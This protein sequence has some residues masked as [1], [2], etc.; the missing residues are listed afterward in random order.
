ML[1]AL[2]VRL[3]SRPVQPVTVRVTIDSPRERAFGFLRDLANRPAFTD[4]FVKR[5]HLERIPS[6]G[7]GASARFRVQPL[8]ARMWM[9]TVVEEL[10]APHLIRERGR[11]GRLDRIPISTAW[12]LVAGPGSATEVAV[13]F[14]TDPSYRLDRIKERFGARRW[15]RRQWSRALRRLKEVLEDGRPIE[16]VAVAGEDQVPILPAGVRH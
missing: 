15:Y 5:F 12:E 3:E 10:R 8:I 1:G 11:G 9:E 7:V 6:A 4:H 13:T 16:P 2:G 14:W